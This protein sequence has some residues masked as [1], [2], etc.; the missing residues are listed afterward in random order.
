MIRPAQIDKGLNV[1]TCGDQCDAAEIGDIFTWSELLNGDSGAPVRVPQADV[2]LI[3]LIPGGTLGNGALVR[4][5]GLIDGVSCFFPLNIDGATPTPAIQTALNSPILLKERP[6]Y[7]RP[8][9]I[10]GDNTTDLVVTLLIAKGR[11][12]QLAKAAAV[13]GAALAEAAIK[14]RQ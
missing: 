4:W 10:A 12:D 1:L 13:A 7:V 11:P 2:S 9:V 14:G 8:N 3:C 6:L 5:E